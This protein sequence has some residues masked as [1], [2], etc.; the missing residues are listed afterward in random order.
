MAAPFRKGRRA[1]AHHLAV[2]VCASALGLSLPH[3][4]SERSLRAMGGGVSKGG[5]T[6]P[7]RL[8]KAEASEEAAT[9]LFGEIDANND[10][11]L[12]LMEIYNVRACRGRIHDGVPPSPC[13]PTSDPNILAGHLGARPEDRGAGVDDG[14]GQG[15]GREARR[16]RRRQDRPAGV[17]IYT[18]THTRARAPPTL[19]TRAHVAPA[20]SPPSSPT[21]RTSASAAPSGRARAARAR[22]RCSPPRPRPRPRPRRRRP[23]WTLRCG[24]RTSTGTR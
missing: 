17:S 15:H 8:Q 4:D 1:P 2:G 3:A 23:R 22:R 11:K 9:K 13:L 19:S 16:R 14:H 21:S 20:G 18:Q 5:V 12:S 7:S 24:R 6:K 10:M